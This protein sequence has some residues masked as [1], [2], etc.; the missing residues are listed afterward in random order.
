M[1]PLLPLFNIFHLSSCPPRPFYFHTLVSPLS[2]LLY[3][4]PLPTNPKSL[5][6]YL[7]DIGTSGSC[8]PRASAKPTLV[9]LHSIDPLPH[10]GTLVE[11]GF[12]SFGYYLIKKFFVC[13]FIS[14]ASPNS[15]Y[16]P[17]FL[18]F[19]VKPS[20]QQSISTLVI[21]ICSFVSLLEPTG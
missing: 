12:P 21:E 2:F 4:V 10:G 1:I 7:V 13:L 6:D 16:G 9:I 19:S 8:L 3:Y 11:R 18:G 17:L 5:M 20:E 15:P 14:L